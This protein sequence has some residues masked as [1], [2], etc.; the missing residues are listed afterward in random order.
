MNQKNESEKFVPKYAGITKR[1]EA[2]VKAKSKSYGKYIRRLI[3]EDM[4]RNS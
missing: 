2:Y 3:S 4:K 1:Q